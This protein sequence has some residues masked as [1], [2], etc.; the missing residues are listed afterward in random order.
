MQLE[1]LEKAGL[2]IGS[3]EPSEDGKALK[4]DEA[5]EADAPKPKKKR[6]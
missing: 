4:Y 3:L 1:R 6:A 5:Q 2:V